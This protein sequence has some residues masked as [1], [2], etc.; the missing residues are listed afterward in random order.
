MG[1]LNPSQVYSETAIPLQQELASGKTPC[2][3]CLSSAEGF[4]THHQRCNR[5]TRNFLV[6]VPAVA[7]IF[8]WA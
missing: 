3:K 1:E 2:W 5:P 8:W 6:S 4:Q 7:T